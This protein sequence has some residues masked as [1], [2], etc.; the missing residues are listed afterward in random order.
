MSIEAGP[1]WERFFDGDNQ[2]RWQELQDPSN[3]WSPH[4]LPWIRVAQGVN[5]DIP[6]VLPRL[7]A[8]AQPTWYCSGR[9]ARGALRLREALQSFIGPSYSDFD[10][11]P[12]LLN[13]EDPVEA[14]FAAGTVAP[15]YLI[16]ASRA[17]DVAKIQRA[18]GLYRGLLER[19]PKRPP[20][21]QRPLGTL[22]A[23]LDRA[24][25]AGDE[26]EA[27]RILERIRSIG[28]LDAENL[29][30]LEVGVRAG[31]GHWREIAEDGALLTQ[32]TGLR[33]PPRVLADVHDALYR[34][35]VEPS[36]DTHAPEQALAAFKFAGLAR[37][38]TLFGMRRGVRNPRV[39]KSFFLYELAREDV[40]SSFLTELAQELER[41][42]DVFARALIGL[43]PSI[44]PQPPADPLSAADAA[45]DDF[46]IDRALELCLQAPPSKKRLTRLIRCAED[47]GT[48]EVARLVLG[49]VEPG[50]ESE[51]LPAPWMARFQA[52]EDR[53]AAEQD[54]Q[55]PQGWLDWARQVGAGMDEDRAMTAL[56]EQMPTWDPTEF[57]QEKE[58]A[59][60]LT[61][62]INNADES[63]EAVFR[64]AS[65]LL[66][67]ALMP[68]TG[69][70]PRTLKPLL[71]L[72][73]TKI[74]LLGDPSLSELEL[75]RDLAATLLLV[76]L[77]QMEYGSLI[78]DLE[79]LMG[80]HLSVFTF[81][82]ALDLAE[83]LAN[84]ACPD[85]ERR[86][87]LV[88]RVIEEARR[89]AHRLSA[90]DS[91]VIGLLCQ[92]YAI[93]C[94]IELKKD[95]DAIASEV[96]EALAGKK[97]G[98]YTLDEPAGQRAAS[99][100]ENR[101]Q[102]VRVELNHDHE[103]TKR[104]IN[105][106][107]TANLFVFAWKSSKHQAF[108]CVKDHRDADNPMVQAQGKGTSSILRAV[109]EYA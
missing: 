48:E 75:A 26:A 18:L 99:L 27:N 73:V 38:S 78:A 39:L 64:E 17:E 103:C 10:G 77:D 37:R 89:L 2:L 46:E 81:G 52:L 91:L 79:D 96:N 13:A 9:S 56:R 47:I 25:A 108:Y 98:I 44:A 95:E 22:R 60:E 45:F 71:R 24:V 83:L 54:K 100:V 59:A 62:I 1:W 76:G 66:Y 11:R 58:Q 90:T 104:L 34:L 21:I 43:Q 55:A 69:A 32:L 36:E 101:C 107:R 23:E 30:Y 65:P 53:V 70:P 40:G 80:A 8:N 42:D 4:V 68:E 86:L 28:R 84:H 92:D 35:H 82:W 102:D 88:L 61:R 41:L 87:R 63:A 57:I 12:Y 31:L 5:T 19:M 3:A 49:A 50:D 106:A 67:Q 109:L 94:P 51:S 6:V 74:A 16:R 20:H 33:L 29:L 14:A 85:S 7:A 93:N 72:L 105:L 97:V 15:A